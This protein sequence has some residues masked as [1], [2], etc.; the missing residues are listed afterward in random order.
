MGIPEAIAGTGSSCAG[1]VTPGIAA[2]EY[3]HRRTKLARALPANSVAII[4]SSDLKYR[5]GAVFYE[6][7]QDSDFLYLTGTA[8]VPETDFRAEC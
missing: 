5:S 2:L 1:T 6:F 8:A 4:A 7:H 3:L